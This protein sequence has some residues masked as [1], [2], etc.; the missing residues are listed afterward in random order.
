MAAYPPRAGGVQRA[1]SGIETIVPGRGIHLKP[2][3]TMPTATVVAAAPRNG[4][5]AIR[6]ILRDGHR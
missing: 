6:H 4:A 2:T 5:A 3:L 1:L